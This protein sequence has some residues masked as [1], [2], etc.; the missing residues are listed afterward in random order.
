MFSCNHTA[1]KP[2][3]AHCN[4]VS[5]YLF[6]VFHD[7]STQENVPSEG[8]HRQSHVF[9][10]LAECEEMGRQTL[11]ILFL[12]WRQRHLNLH[13]SERTWA[14]GLIPLSCNLSATVLDWTCHPTPTPH[15]LPSSPC[16]W[17]DYSKNFVK[18]KK[19]KK[20]GTR[21][22]KLSEDRQFGPEVLHLGLRMSTER[23]Y[24]PNKVKWHSV[25]THKLIKVHETY[26][27]DE[28][29]SNF[30]LLLAFLDNDFFS[31]FCRTF[32]NLEKHNCSFFSF[33][34]GM[35]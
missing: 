11:K 17:K 26:V 21:D 24:N 25:I 34:P 29:N 28:N 33:F 5:I 9:P 12:P 20:E 18:K 13:N 19:Q 4:I 7:S 22:L 8:E 27:L 30:L 3:T 32:P 10:Q 1:H 16:L 35:Y 23:Y 6:W 14:I 31:C 15:P 2:W